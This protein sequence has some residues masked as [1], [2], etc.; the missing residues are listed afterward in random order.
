MMYEAVYRWHHLET[1]ETGIRCKEFETES[2]FLAELSK[3]NRD[4][5]WLY[6]PIR[7]YRCY[8]YQAE[9]PAEYLE[10]VTK[11]VVEKR[12]PVEYFTF[13]GRCVMLPK[14]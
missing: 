10:R 1:G 6:A 8:P 13:E 4:P 12:A 11:A 9:A 2:A 5:R 14:E 7:P 3:W